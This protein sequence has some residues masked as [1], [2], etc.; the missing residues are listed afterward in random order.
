[1]YE[2]WQETLLKVELFG[3]IT[4]EQLDGI[5]I[6]LKP[7]IIQFKK[8][9]NI[10]IAG[11]AYAGIGIVLAGE[12]L[13]SKENAGGNRVILAKLPSGHIFG[14]MI[15]FS[16]INVWPAT[17]VALEDSA[18]MFIEPYRII[19]TCEKVCASHTTLIL[20]ML[21]IVSKKALMLNRKVEYLAIKSMREKISTFLLEQYLMTN[22]S[23]FMIDLNRNELADFLN[24]SRPSMSREI[25][26]MKE[27]GIIDYYK[28]S[29]KIINMDLLRASI[30]A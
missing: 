4:Q 29:F 3:E 25:A 24:V 15:A 22:K 16:N 28:A 10:S 6:C 14:E 12:I 9:E 8:N 11:E 23:T 18:I 21:K 30:G 7:K 19:G 27:E 13:V 5:L 2:Q 1:M 26:K 20:N 17:V